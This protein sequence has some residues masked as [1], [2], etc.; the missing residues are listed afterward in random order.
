MESKNTAI[1]S[2]NKKNY[3]LN[4]SGIIFNFLDLDFQFFFYLYRAFT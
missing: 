4:S 3:Q 1:K 2:N